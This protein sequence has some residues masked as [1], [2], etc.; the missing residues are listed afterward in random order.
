MNPGCLPKNQQGGQHPSPLRIL[1][2]SC[3]CALL[4][5]CANPQSSSMLPPSESDLNL[6]G[7]DHLCQSKQEAQIRWLSPDSRETPWGGGTEFF[8]AHTIPRQEGQWVIF[9][10]DDILVGQITAFPDGLSL[11]SYPKLQHTL[12]QLPPA[13]EFFFDSSQLLKGETPDSA[14]LYRTGKATTT[15]QYYIRH[16][17]G[18]EDRLVMAIFVL[19][20]YETLLDG[21]HPRFLSYVKAPASRRSFSPDVSPSSDTPKEFL[22]LQQFARGE[23]SLF[24]SCGNK[25]PARAADAYQKAIEHGLS[26]KKQLSEAHHRLGLA[27]ISLDQYQEAVSSIQNALTI[28]PHSARILNSY[29]TALG[30]I[31]KHTESI[32]AFEKSLALLPAFTSARF[33][34]ASALESFNPKRAIQEYETFIVLVE[35]NPQER[36]RARLA[37]ERIKSLQGSRHP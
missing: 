37:Q 22:G 12:S 31:G 13:R 19:D 5:H 26:D 28:Q 23:I 35:G 30:H 11:D 24:A 14:T 7:Q 16:R 15:H 20:P 1:G 21:N 4:S 2:I 27:Y 10:E 17:H 6:M 32:A 34:L 29:G 8:Q 9:N 36:G 33:N 3:L 18:Q 25:K